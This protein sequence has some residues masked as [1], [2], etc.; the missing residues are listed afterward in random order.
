MA[1][2]DE[3][4][5]MGVNVREGMDRV[6]GD[7][8]LYTMMLGMF[9]T[10][11]TN[12]A[13]LPEEFDGGDIDGVIR[14]VHTLKGTTGNLSITPLFNGYMETLTLLRANKPGEAKKTFC[15]MLPTQE[16][17]IDCIQRYQ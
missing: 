17:I 10:E 13:V 15:A 6:M 3:L 4:K 14:K 12:L 2:L 1:L 16:K 11:V 5:D 9:L 7:E 8:S